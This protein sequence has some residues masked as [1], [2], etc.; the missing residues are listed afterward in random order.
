MRARRESRMRA[1]AAKLRGLV[2]GPSDDQVDDEIREHLTLLTERFVAQ[3]MSSEE[4]ARAARRQFGN[5]TV[6]Q[7]DR[8]HMQ[9]FPSVEAWW[10]DLRYALRFAWRDRVVTVVSV[11]TLG[12]GIGAATAIFS[13][14]YNVLLAPFPEIGAERMVFA[15][16]QNPQQGQESG[17]Q[18]YTATEILEF[19]EHSRSFDG[20]IA[21]TGEGVRYRHGGGTEQLRGALVTPGTFEFFG[22]PALHGRVMQPGDYEPGA[23]PVFMMRH[24]TWMTR[25]NGDL[26]LLNKAFVLNGTGRTM[27]GIMPP[28]FAWYGADLWIPAQLQPEAKTGFADAPP[29][30]FMLGRLKPG[31][32][33]QQAE[34]DLA[35]IASGLARS[36]P[37]IYPPRFTVQVRTRLD[38]VLSRYAPF[39]S[40]LHTVLAAVGLLL[41]IACSNVAHLMLARATAREKEF[42]L[43]TV[44]GAGR[45]RLVR[46]LMVESLV[47]ATAG[48]MLGLLVAS[49]GLKLLVAAVPPNLIPAQAVIEL[50]APV[51]TFTLCVAVLT[52]L[53]F[54]LVPALHASRRD[55][56]DPLRDSGKGVSGGFRGRWLRDTLVVMEVALSLTLL[57]GAGLVMRSF[58]ALRQEH[59]GVQADHVF[60]TSLALPADAYTP[61]EQVSRFFQPLLA[62]VKA[63]PGVV[64]AAASSTLP[65]YRDGQTKIAIAG[66]THGEE[67]LTLFQHVSEEY[68]RVLR[69]E[70][71][72]GRP[73]SEAEIDGAR[74]VAVVN[75][76][77]GRRYLPNDD[78]VGRRVRLA[79]RGTAEGPEHDAWFDIVGVV[80]D[81]RNG[82]LQVATEP[83]VWL[84]Y[85]LIGSAPDALMVRTSQDPGTIANAVRQAVWSTDSGVALVNPGTLN[86]LI[87]EQLYTAPRFGFLVMTMFGCIGLILVTVGVYSVL[88]YSTTQRT[89]EIGIR[90]AL[91]AERSAVVGMVVRAGLRLVVAGIALGIGVSLLLVRFIETQLA[92]MTPY[93]PATL[94]ATTAL[95]T[96]TGAIA[97]WIPARRAARVDP[98]VALRYE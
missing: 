22:M 31:E 26:S 64:D 28:R 9:T 97:C 58:V 91:G 16:I 3:G 79:R 94:A 78:P 50:N 63:L 1:F 36:H 35:V 65:P 7:E 62:R 8:R 29:R 95:L 72:R 66:K 12:L 87:S 70:F 30:W 61:A 38:A 81:V 54:G 49:G 15:R 67:W 90:M 13:V 57:I 37:Q 83:E 10:H 89:H 5:I 59:L 53:I 96:I 14:I 20:I 76:T 44:L 68:F 25:F 60:Q 43:R 48:A 32:S 71:K 55:V 52:T 82:G 69:I 18:G 41:L 46:L 84:P 4:A 93:D 27:V 98:L 75:E 2:H 51:L 73:F 24:K 11:V 45:M 34:A 92:G 88:A 17:R 77:F 21:A 47:L 23:P 6:L 42:T 19:T 86:D 85:T 39:E 74:R 33:T 56:N 80:A 40:T